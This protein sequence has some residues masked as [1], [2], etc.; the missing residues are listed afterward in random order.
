MK[1]C[2]KSFLEESMFPQLQPCT[3]GTLRYV[4]SILIDLRSHFNPGFTDYDFVQSVIENFTDSISSL[5]S[6]K[7]VKL[8]FDIN[9]YFKSDV[10]KR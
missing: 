3:A 5:C 9:E 8:P 7:K 10:N 6:Q 2:N 4:R 1:E